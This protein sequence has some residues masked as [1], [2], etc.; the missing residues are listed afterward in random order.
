ME[1]AAERG[2]VLDRRIIGR[3]LTFRG[4]LAAIKGDQV[5]LRDVRESKGRFYRDHMWILTDVSRVFGDNGYVHFTGK[6]CSYRHQSLSFNVNGKWT[7]IRVP[8][9]VTK[10][11]IREIRF[12]EN[13]SGLTFPLLDTRGKVQKIRKI[14][15]QYCNGSADLEECGIFC[16]T[17]GPIEEAY[18]REVA[19]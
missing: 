4:K 11:T 15:C 7:S 6:L 10:Y 9:F 1:Q 16:D 3:R 8:Y 12:L 17:C 5:L 19:L 18:D 14:R 2:I 13:S